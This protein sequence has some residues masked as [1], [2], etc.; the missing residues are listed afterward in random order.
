VV[1][2]QAGGD[3]GLKRARD[4][5]TRGSYNKASSIRQAKLDKN[6]GKILNKKLAARI[7]PGLAVAAEA[8][9]AYVSAK[10]CFEK[11]ERK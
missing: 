6:L 11:A 1:Y 7:L 3:A 2:E 10:K 4:L 5:A 8:Y 9:D